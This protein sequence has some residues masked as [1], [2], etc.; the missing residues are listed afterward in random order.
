MIFKDRDEA[1]RALAEPVARLLTGG[2]HQ[3]RPLVLALPRGGVPVAVPVAQRIGADL[4]I[5]LAR[6][7]GAPGRPEFGIG[8]IAEDGPPVFDETA[9]HYLGLAPDDLAGTVAAAREWDSPPES[10]IVRDSME[11]SI[12]RL[13][14]DSGIGR[15]MLDLRGGDLLGQELLQRMIGV[16]YRPETERFSH[17]VAARAGRQFDLLVHVDTTTALRPLEGWSA[18]EEPTRSRPSWS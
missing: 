4:D 9:L 6:K 16:V 14:H 15:G 12:E 7:I 3:D 17:Y 2:A 8:A 1:G 13:L 18:V 11:G 5:V 10:R